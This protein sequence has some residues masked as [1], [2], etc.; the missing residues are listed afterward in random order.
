MSKWEFSNKVFSA[1]GMLIE[2]EWRK[3]DIELE[4]HQKLIDSISKILEEEFDN[5]FSEFEKIRDS[6]KNERELESLYMELEGKG[7]NFENYYAIYYNSFY[8]NVYT[9]IENSLL[10]IC[11]DRNCKELFKRIKKKD[12]ES[13]ISHYFRV[14]K[15][16]TKTKNKELKSD[17]KEIDG[18]YRKLRN[19][20]VHNRYLCSLEDKR[21]LQKLDGVS[22]FTSTTSNSEYRIVIEDKKLLLEFITK[23]R[24]FIKGVYSFYHNSII[25]RS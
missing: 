15:S 13:H 23:A 24:E 25:E 14:I 2:S 20:L 6:N 18:N 11:E 5:L 12:R 4:Y 1:L 22:F 8:I 17:L 3:I 19:R 21:E 7:Y 9:I 10:M 16:V